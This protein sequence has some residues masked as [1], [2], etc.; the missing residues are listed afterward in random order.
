MCR[1]THAPKTQKAEGWLIGAVGHFRTAFYL[2]A[3]GPGVART[4]N[5]G[6]S[7]WAGGFGWPWGKRGEYKRANGVSVAAGV[8]LPPFLRRY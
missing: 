4:G 5:S 1:P 8:Y 3:P 7:C 6:G 2:G